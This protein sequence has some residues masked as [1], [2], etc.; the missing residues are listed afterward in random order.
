[1]QHSR[2]YAII[3]ILWMQG[4]SMSARGRLITGFIVGFAYCNMPRFITEY[5]T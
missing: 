3:Y 4:R 2:F 5:Q 1:M